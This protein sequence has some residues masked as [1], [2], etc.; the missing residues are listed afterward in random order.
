MIILGLSCYFHD[1]A[2]ALCIDGKIVAA[3]EEERF[4]RR[5]HDRRFPVSAIKYC[6]AEAS[7]RPGDIDL[8]AFYEKPLRKLD[9]LLRI[10]RHYGAQARDVTAKAI[11]LQ[12]SEGLRLEE[13]LDAAIGYQ[14]RVAYVDHHMSHAASAYYCSDFPDAAILVVDGVGEWSTTSQFTGSG[15]TITSQREIRYPHSLGLL[16]ATLTAFLGFRVNNDEYK[17][18]GLASYGRPAAREAMEKLIRIRADGSFEL[19]LEY[20]SFMYDEARMYTDRLIQL[21]GPPRHPSDPISP[22]HMDIAASVQAVT[23]DAM[24]SL[25]GS[26]DGMT[27]SPNLC[28]AGGVA[29]NC[30]ANTRV[31]E[32][33]RFTRP[34]VQPAAGDNGGAIGAALYAYHSSAGASNPAPSQGYDTCLGPSF[35]PAEIQA[36]L[37]SHDLEYRRLGREALC[38]HAATLIWQDCIVGWFQGR[39]EFGPRALGKR[40]I[41]ANPCNPDM[42]DILNSRVKFRE[43]FR[44]FAP[45][46]VA[47][48]AAEYFDISTPSP[49]MLFTPQVRGEARQMIPAVTHVDGTARIQ[50]VTADDDPLFHQLITEFG[51]RSGVPVVVNTSFNMRGEPIVCTPQEAVASFLHCDIDYLIIGPFIVTKSRGSTGQQRT[52]SAGVIQDAAEPAGRGGILPPPSLGPGAPT[53]L[54]AAVEILASDPGLNQAGISDQGPVGPFVYPH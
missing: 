7:I 13:T 2:A 46:V 53:W 31:A 43:D 32:R 9:R 47:E 27:D 5:K 15:A 6:L 8:V 30:V 25:V 45:A 39:M 52:A 28:M 17:V 26:F 40:S 33:T 36:V 44:P 29:L 16:Y 10:G 3:A 37:D 24:V 38:A 23:E 20:F 18:M 54:A 50:T 4:T 42:M 34:F 1:A 12:L 41:L 14:G 22:R 48:R 19:D 49:F 35:T 21:L 11:R 51:R